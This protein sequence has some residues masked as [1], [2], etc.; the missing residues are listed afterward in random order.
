[1]RSAGISNRTPRCRKFLSRVRISAATRAAR[2]PPFGPCPMTPVQG[3]GRRWRDHRQVINEWIISVDSSVVRAH[4]TL[5]APGKRG[6]SDGIDALTVDGEG[7]G[8]FRGGIHLAVDGRGLP[9]RFLLTPGQAGDNPQLLPPL[10]GIN[11]ARLGPRR[12]RCGRRR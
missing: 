6:C 9:M 1:M 5:R 4:R 12:P 2:W 11:V 7:I 8:R 10:D 3:G